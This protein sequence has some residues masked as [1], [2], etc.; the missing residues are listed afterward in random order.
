MDGPD[1]LIAECKQLS[2]V[3]MSLDDD[4]DAGWV[5]MTLRALSSCSHVTKL[6]VCLSDDRRDDA[7]EELLADYIKNTSALR[8]L[9]LIALDC[10]INLT[11]ALKL[12]S[13]VR[14]LCLAIDFTEEAV[15]RFATMLKS[16]ENIYALNIST[17][18]ESVELLVHHLY[19]GLSRNQTLISLSCYM[20]S[21]PLTKHGYFVRDIIRRNNNLVRS[22]AHCATG[23][24]SRRCVEAF[25]VVAKHPALM[26]KIC[27]IQSVG[28][29][30]VAEIV[31]NALG[32]VLGFDYYMRVSGVVKHCVVCASGNAHKLQLSDIDEY[33][34]RL[35][36]RFL[37]VSDILP[38]TS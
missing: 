5:K 12:N 8:E 13:S 22:A 21:L 10:W 35:I 2:D 19:P 17:A 28:E 9:K 36:R 29:E 20:K 24:H 27:E 6:D 14:K 38:T 30:D 23:I 15:F 34:W 33:S 37:R 4:E 11:E 7:V 1:I 25:E 16:S 31:R 18:E 32:T 3:S 26:E